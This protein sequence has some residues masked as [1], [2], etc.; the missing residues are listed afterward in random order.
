MDQ[1]VYIGLAAIILI[2][3]AIF[4][5]EQTLKLVRAGILK[6]KSLAKDAIL[7]SGQEQEDWVVEN[8][9]PL[10][11]LPVKIFVSEGLFRIIVKQ[12]YSAAKDLMDDGR[13]NHS[14]P[15]AVG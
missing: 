5:W 12:V 15:D 6:A 8:V 13:L 11:P 10:I 14:R 3:I 2:I 1:L 9:Y 7:T 4:N